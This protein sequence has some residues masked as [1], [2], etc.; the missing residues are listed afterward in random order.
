MNDYVT[1]TLIKGEPDE[2]YKNEDL[3]LIAT[4]LESEGSPLEAMLALEAEIT[5]NP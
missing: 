1:F 4:K 2:K 3:Y 5:R